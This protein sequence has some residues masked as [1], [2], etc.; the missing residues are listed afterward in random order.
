VRDLAAQEFLVALERGH[1]LADVAAAKRHDVDGG[2]LQV[3]AHAHFRHRD[4][5]PFQDGIVHAALGENVGDRMAH[6]LADAQLPLRAV[7]R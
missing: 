1:H 5:V 7:R 3:G 6:E 2:K 4:Q